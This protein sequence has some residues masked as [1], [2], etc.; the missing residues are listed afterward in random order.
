MEKKLIEDLKPCPF[1]GGKAMTH[2]LKSGESLLIYC[3]DCLAEL[4]GGAPQA[5]IEK[6]NTRTA[7]SSEPKTAED[8]RID[9]RP[10]KYPPNCIDEILKRESEQATP[11]LAAMPSD[12]VLFVDWLYK[13]EYIMDDIGGNIS[14]L[15][16]A[17]QKSK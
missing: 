16:T 3:Q 12:A 2:A 14:E 17:Y 1:C 4:E 6:W 13:M 11:P 7:L 8:W 5:T 10:I 9:I 15:Y